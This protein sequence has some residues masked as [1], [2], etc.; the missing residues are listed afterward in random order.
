MMPGWV[1]AS[2][3]MAGVVVVIGVF[4]SLVTERGGSQSA[5]QTPTLVPTSPPRTPTTYTDVIVWRFCSGVLVGEVTKEQIRAVRDVDVSKLSKQREWSLQ[6]VNWVRR[7]LA[8][9]R[10]TVEEA[11]EI[12]QLCRDWRR[13]DWEQHRP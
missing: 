13:A 6:V 4:G 12:N 9:P 5:G 8:Q 7:S 10:G 3:A 2:L 11:A 1:W